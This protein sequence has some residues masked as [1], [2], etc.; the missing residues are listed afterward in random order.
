MSNDSR[1]DDFPKILVDEEDRRAYHQKKQVAAHTIRKDSP[2]QTAT[3]N[4]VA[5]NR[6]KGNGIWLIIIAMFA[7]AACAG[8]YYLYTLFQNQ[9]IIAKQAE[10]RIVELENKLSATGEEIGEST[11]A[12]QVKVTD[13][14]KKTNDLWEQMDKLWASAWRRNQKEI[15]DLVEKT[16]DMQNSLSSSVRSV[17]QNV[18]G[19]KNQIA[20]LKN[21]IAAMA[22]E[23]LALNVRLEQTSGDKAKQAQTVKNLTDKLT[24]LEQRNNA[25]ASRISTLESELRTM[26]TK[27]VS[28]PNPSGQ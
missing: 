12:L 17:S 15:A 27:V 23:V 1:D 5:E 13:L 20:A 21:E 14:S 18:E 16:N 4:G 3:G 7:L 19:Q 22:D 8:C 6:S 28:S 11:V 9:Q 24:V 2:E 26:A 25:L 10:A